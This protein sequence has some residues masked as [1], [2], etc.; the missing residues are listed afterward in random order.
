MLECRPKSDN[1]V[2]CTACASHHIVWHLL[3]ERTG[4]TVLDTRSNSLRILAIKPSNIILFFLNHSYSSI[5]K[6]SPSSI[7][8]RKKQYINRDFHK[9]SLNSP[10]RVQICSFEHKDQI[11][12]VFEQFL[13]MGTSNLFLDCFAVIVVWMRLFWIPTSGTW[14]QLKF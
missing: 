11:W 12:T 13:G 9:F 5:V 4:S 1:M 10:K 3:P 8:F 6:G 7:I 2:S 14:K